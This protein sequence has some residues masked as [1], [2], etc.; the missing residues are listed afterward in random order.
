MKNFLAAFS[1]SIIA[2]LLCASGAPAQQVKLPPVPPSEVNLATAY[3]YLSACIVQAE[4]ISPGKTVVLA[5]LTDS[6][7]C[8]TNF[9]H[10]AVYVGNKD[11]KPIKYLGEE[12]ARLGRWDFNTVR[13]SGSG[14]DFCI[15]EQEGDGGDSRVKYVFPAEPAG[16]RPV[17]RREYEPLAISSLVYHDGGVYFASGRRDASVYGRIAVKNGK[18]NSASILKTETGTMIGDT[19]GAGVQNGVYAVES[20]SGRYVFNGKAWEFLPAA[21]KGTPEILPAEIRLQENA[22]LDPTA[23]STAS[24]RDESRPAPAEQKTQFKA[25]PVVARVASG[26]ITVDSAG[27]HTDYRIPPVDKEAFSKYLGSPDCDPANS[28]GPYTTYVDSAVFGVYVYSGEGNCGL[29]GLGFFDAKSGKYA[30]RYFKETAPYSTTAL[31]V[32][33][34]T[35]YAGLSSETEYS[36]GGE[37]LAK[38]NL[39]DGSVSLYRIPELVNAIL[40]SDGA[41]FAGTDDGIFAIYP[42]GLTAWLRL[43]FEPATGDCEYTLDEPEKL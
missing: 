39:R 37:G 31:L 7:D 1:V 18:M 17:S 43:D 19:T 24:V 13:I 21:R 10:Y 5:G 29:G 42:S 22:T 8:E 23:F 15:I 12:T 14:K 32:K 41:V 11:N 27:V 6:P 25:A 3:K 38:I 4:Q 35:V 26:M 33:G 34:D 36:S 40:E 30:F 20:E 16:A 28:I 2:A 9:T